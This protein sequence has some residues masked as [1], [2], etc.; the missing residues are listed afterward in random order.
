MF[1]TQKKRSERCIKN[2]GVQDKAGKLSSLLSVYVLCRLRALPVQNMSRT[3]T[4]NPGGQS[5]AL[6]SCVLKLVASCKIHDHH[7]I[8]RRSLVV[9]LS[10]AGSGTIVADPLQRTY[11]GTG[12]L[13]CRTPYGVLCRT[14]LLPRSSLRSASS[15]YLECLRTLARNGLK[16]R[17]ITKPFVCNKE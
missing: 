6:S 10:S 15:L 17:H 16:E 14:T 9:S 12:A 11:A 3:S 8:V 7:R 13:D 5:F 2:W 4:E 1:R